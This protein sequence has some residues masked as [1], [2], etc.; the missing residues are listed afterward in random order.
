MHTLCRP[1]NLP[2]KHIL[3][4]HWSFQFD[5][6][7]PM[8]IGSEHR[9]A[10]LSWSF[11]QLI[12]QS[13]FSSRVEE[14]IVVAFDLHQ[15]FTLLK[16]GACRKFDV[17]SWGRQKRSGNNCW[18]SCSSRRSTY[19]RLDLTGI[20]CAK[21]YAQPTSTMLQSSRALENM[22][23]AAQVSSTLKSL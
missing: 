20:L 11:P 13:F 9:S 17:Q 18:T 22:S 21:Q 8:S 7:S 16:N 3:S 6:L 15:I 4:V 19:S 5:C 14:G 2:P 1:V 10:G 23:T 12:S